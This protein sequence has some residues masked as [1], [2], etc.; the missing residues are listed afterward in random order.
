MK[1]ESVESYINALSEERREVFIRLRSVILKNL[2][3]GFREE[4]S[5]GMI[6]YVV[7]LEIYPR[8]YHAGKNLPLPFINLAAQKNYISLYHLGL[9]A[10]K[11]LFDWFYGEFQKKQYPHKL[12]AGKSCLRFKYP[13]EIPYDLIEELVGKISVEDWIKLYEEGHPPTGNN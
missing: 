6:G 10:K 3:K 1:I 2:P 9:Y 5:Y 8:G 7:P 4:I 13:D 11:D 12:D